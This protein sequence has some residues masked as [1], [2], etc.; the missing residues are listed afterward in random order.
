M[1]STQPREATI[2]YPEKLRLRTPRGLSAAL[3]QAAGRNHTSPSEWARQTLLRGLA[4]EGVSLCGKGAG[5]VD[6]DSV[7]DVGCTDE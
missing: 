2:R 5:H 3:Q 1:H 7:Q 6:N 4:A